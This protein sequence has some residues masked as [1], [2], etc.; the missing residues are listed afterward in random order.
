MILVIFLLLLVVGAPAKPAFSY[1]NPQE[2]NLGLFITGLAGNHEFK[3]FMDGALSSLQKVLLANGYK[4]EQFLTFSEKNS[5]KRTLENY[6]KETAK[7]PKP[8]ANVFIFIAGHANGHDEDAFFHLRG[9]DVSYKTMMEW[10]GSIPAKQ[11]ILVVAA[12]QGEAWIKK[13]GKPGRIIIV[14]NGLQKFDFIPV[15]F[16][17]LFPSMFSPLAPVEK[18]KAPVQ[19][20]LKDVFLKTQK[21]VQ[22]WYR[23]NELMP[24]EVA[25]IDADGDGK[26]ENLLD[27]I[28]FPPE[29]NLPDA[30][31]DSKM[32]ESI[33]FLVPTTPIGKHHGH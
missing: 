6:M 17:R 28:D 26:G 25:E 7:R 30:R 31:P 2:E 3:I 8:Y 15:T 18:D 29:K 5:T 24:T 4:E 12:S 14:G 23:V 22:D 20:S 19:I 32:A 16:L 13:L 21:G 11:M 1:A 27:L 33:I 9:T 10:I